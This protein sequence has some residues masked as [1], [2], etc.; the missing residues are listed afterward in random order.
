M[1][2]LDQGGILFGEGF[3]EVRVVGVQLRRQIRVADLEP[4]GEPAVALQQTALLA[5][6]QHLVAFG[7]SGTED[8]T[9]FDRSTALHLLHG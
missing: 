2:H 3:Q 5:A 7:F 8:V 6:F 4:D 1:D 9:Q